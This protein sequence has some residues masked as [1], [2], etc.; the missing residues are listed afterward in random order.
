MARTIFY[1]DNLLKPRIYV[2]AKIIFF[3]FCTPFFN[4]NLQYKYSIF[5]ICTFLLIWFLKILIPKRF[6]IT[7]KHNR[8]ATV[9]LNNGHDTLNNIGRH[10]YIFHLTL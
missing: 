2:Y 10:R 4:N 5:I 9:S 8:N 6:M 1:I 3:N 7:F